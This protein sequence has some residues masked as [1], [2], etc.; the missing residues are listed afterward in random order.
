MPKKKKQTTRAGISATK[1]RTAA[2]LTKRIEQWSEANGNDAHAETTRQLLG[3][4][5]VP[6]SEKWNAQKPD[7]SHRFTG[8]NRYSCCNAVV[9]N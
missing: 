9:V 6:E 4:V 5:S 2:A 3:R 7:R 1:I 8:T